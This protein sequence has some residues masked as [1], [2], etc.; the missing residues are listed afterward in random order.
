MPTSTEFR[1]GGLTLESAELR[2]LDMP[3]KFDFETSFG[4]MRRRFVPLLILRAGGLESVAEGVM[5]HLPLYREETIPGAL[6]LLEGQLLPRLLGRTF[7]TPEAFAQAL[8]PY[9]GNRMA[10]AMLE[11]AFWDLWAR[12][13]GLP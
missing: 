4:V 11:M 6:A 9:R 7:A 2:V 3:L 12:A 10:R 5:D 13:L 1:S 8:A